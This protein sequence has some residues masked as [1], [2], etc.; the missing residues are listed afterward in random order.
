[1]QR[2]WN[3]WD[4]ILKNKTGQGMTEYVLILVLLVVFAMFSVKMFGGKV[5]AAAQR[6]GDAITNGS[7]CSRPSSLL[8]QQIRRN[9]MKAPTKLFKENSGQGMTEYVLLVVL[10]AIALIVAYHY[11]GRALQNR[12]IGTSNTLYGATDN[13][14]H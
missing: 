3:H 11:Y 4:H 14:G 13:C 12:Y 5:G 10:V 2:H 1:M 8:I 9:S 7:C 6:A